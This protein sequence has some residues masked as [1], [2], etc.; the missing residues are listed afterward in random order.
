MEGKL[1]FSR[2]ELTRP[3]LGRPM[4]F[5][6]T[7]TGGP[8]GRPGVSALILRTPGQPGLGWCLL[9]DHPENDG[10]SVTNGAMDYADAVCRALECSRMDLA[11]FEMDS[12]GC[13]DELHLLV[14]EA[15]F[16]PVHEP[17]SKPRTL[18]AFLRRAERVLGPLP[19][20]FTVAVNACALRF[21]W[22]NRD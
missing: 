6:V 3:S 15:R 21:G 22:R 20:E 13:I 17:D 12:M 1:W 11:W 9:A 14:D 7:L 8:T 16:A 10:V 5:N 4:Q 2:L 19:A 18:V